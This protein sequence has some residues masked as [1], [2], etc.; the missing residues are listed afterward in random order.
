MASYR[1]ITNWNRIST[2]QSRAILDLLAKW[3]PQTTKKLRKRLAREYPDLAEINISA[4]RKRLNKLIKVEGERSKQMW[5]IN[6]KKVKKMVD[7]VNR[8]LP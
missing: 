5:S 1:K 3:G 7:R 8:W 6:E 4:M 2:P